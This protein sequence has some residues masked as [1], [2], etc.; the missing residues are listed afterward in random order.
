MWVPY[1]L[2]FETYQALAP[3]QAIRNP[4][5]LETAPSR[6]LK[7]FYSAAARKTVAD[8]GSLSQQPSLLY[9]QPDSQENNRQPDCPRQVHGAAHCPEP[10]K[11]IDD[12]TYQ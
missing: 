5:Y 7:G 10:A 8:S 9:C 4:H 3:R 6:F 11:L 1:P 2:S 12:R